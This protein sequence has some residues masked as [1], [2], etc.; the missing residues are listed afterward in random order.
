MLDGDLLGTFEE[1]LAGDDRNRA[2]GIPMD[3]AP[4]DGSIRWRG[5]AVHETD[6][7]AR[8]A[9]KGLAGRRRTLDVIC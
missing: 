4:K 6:P 5:L 2:R 8:L 1:R 3:R 7:F 9:R